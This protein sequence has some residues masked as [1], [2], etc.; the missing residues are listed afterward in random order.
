MA[1]ETFKT[2]IGAEE[3]KYRSYVLGQKILD[4]GFRPTHMVALWR[5]GASVGCYVHEFLQYFNLDVDHIPIRTYREGGELQVQGLRYVINKANKNDRL[6][7][8]DDVFDTGE[9]A[10]LVLNTIK[11]KM[12]L[13]TPHDIRTA[14]LE[15]KPEKN[16][17]S[18][19]PDFYITALE[20]NNWRYYPHELQGLDL[21]LIYDFHGE[22]VGD[23]IRD[24]MT[25]HQ[26][27]PLEEEVGR[28]LDR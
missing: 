26:I 4:A 1:E 11:E 16:D 6:L 13:N 18:L 10:E 3:F 21:P 12:R 5:G 9:T 14:F 23:L 24:T 7:V 22:K 15:Y 8:V 2:F 20:K 28:G 17:S 19:Q 27:R 25:R